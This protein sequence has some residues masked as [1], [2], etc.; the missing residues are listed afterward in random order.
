MGGII[1][2]LQRRIIIFT[3]SDPPPP[4]KKNQPGGLEIDQTRYRPCA[5]K[6]YQND[7]FSRFLLLGS[8]DSTVNVSENNEKREKCR[9]SFRHERLARKINTSTRHFVPI[10]LSYFRFVKIPIW[11]QSLRGKRSPGESRGKFVDKR[12][13]MVFFFCFC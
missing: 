12:F 11:S 9:I 2:K 3:G 13:L 6:P 8:F 1:T 5:R 7:I 10:V 4:E